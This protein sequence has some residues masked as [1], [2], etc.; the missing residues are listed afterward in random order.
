MKLR[1]HL[2]L[3]VAGAMTP[4]VGVA[5]VAGV[6][7]VRHE[8]ESIERD[9][10]GRTRAAM[11]A[12][13]AGI[14]GAVSAIEALASSRH[15]EA[16]DIRAFH[17]E[18][19]R[20]LASQ[21]YWHN[22]GLVSATK[23][24]L[25]D[26]ILPFGKPAASIGDQ[27][28]LD[29]VIRT[30]RVA[31]GNVAV[32]TAIS[33]PSVR[34][35]FPIVR[36]GAVRYVLSVP[37]KLEY[38]GEVLRAQQLPGDWVIVLVDRNQRFIT[39]IPSRPPGDPISQSFRE[40]LARAP[41]GFFHG[42]TVEGL[43]T[44]T[45]YV[46]SELSGW[47]LGIAVPASVIEAGARRL[48][49]TMAGGLLVA[50]AVAWWLAWLMAKRI[51]GP[52]GS[53]ASSTRTPGQAGDLAQ[54][55]PGRIQE[56]VQLHQALT[57]SAQEVRER[58]ERLERETTAL[59]EAEAALKVANQAKDEFLAMLGHEL[60]NP[61]G[62]ITSAAGLLTSAGVP[63]ETTQRARAVI[64]RQTQ[65]LSRLVDDLLDVGRVTSGKVV[66]VRRSIDLARVTTDAVAGWRS[67]GRLGHHDV[68]VKASPV[69]VD[70]DE[71]RIEQI[72]TNL[73]GNA[74]KYT[75]AGGTVRIEVWGDRDEARLRVE[76]N[77]PG[78]PP[79]LVDKVFDLFVQGDRPLDRA[80]GGL[81][82]GL[83]LV[84]MLVEMHGGSVDV[85]STEPG[86]GATFTV[87]LPRIAAPPAA[88]T[89]ATG[90]PEIAARRILLIEDNADAREMLSVQLAMDGH[91]VHQAEDGPSGIEKALA[92]RPDLALV[93]IGLPGVDGYEV[94]R[95]IRAT[96]AG[97]RM[98][99]IALTGY[100]QAEDKRRAEEAGF[101]GHLVKPVTPDVLRSLV[102]AAPSGDA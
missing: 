60:R 74:L 68:S 81:G 18:S 42:R 87:R 102:P 95:R 66:L 38:F 16:G 89:V 71:T 31:V 79:H 67:A 65:H 32:G 48:G 59:K 8:R 4:L 5:I 45:P 50:V 76:D 70:A 73:L 2:S 10:V 96:E 35:R 75:P 83:T 77:G 19:R 3:L 20:V 29:R 44:Y 27:D 91:E 40:A 69:W 46:T 49:F 14:R 86:P 51:A 54:A 23:V 90:Q 101:D 9:A 57:A 15:L 41:E 24:Q 61:L 52:I 72:V 53:L 7:L 92:I 94:A 33:I 78:I 82:I 30:G 93:D 25:F 88:A 99:L 63:E 1:S 22:I 36:D 6:L 47:V 11:T 55:N 80:H 43:Q 98:L 84:K 13:D 85:S 100:G 17:D 12:V 21:P 34:I 28:T 56:I 58:Q 64:H 26:A 62:A 39:R 37:L 97:R